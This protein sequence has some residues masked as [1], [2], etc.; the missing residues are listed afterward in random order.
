M[1]KDTPFHSFRHTF[2]HYCRLASIPT[3]VHNEITGHETG[4]VADNYG[5]MSYPLAPLVEGMGRYRVP[6]FKLP[7][8]PAAFRI[9][10]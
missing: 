8:P 10:V 6:G 9:G 7:P 3:D 2:K 1:G 5:G 4:D